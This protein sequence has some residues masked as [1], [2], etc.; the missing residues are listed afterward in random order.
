MNRLIVLG[1]SVRAAAFSAQRAGFAP[2][3]IDLFADCDLADACPAV[4]ISRYPAEFLTAL[5]AAPEAPWLYCGGLE[6]SPRLVDQLAMI[7]PLLGNRGGVLRLVRDPLRLGKAVREAGLSFPATSRATAAGGEW[8]IKPRRSS[9]GLGIRFCTKN[10]VSSLPRGAYL[11][12]YVDGDA[13]S[14]VFV[15]AGGRAVFLGATKQWLGRDFKMSRPFLYVGSIG[16]LRL[17]DVE[18]ERLCRLGNVLAERFGLTGLFNVDFVR[19]GEGLWPVEVNPRYSASMEVIE[20]M[21]GMALIDL[22]VAA[23]TSGLLPTQPI[24]PSQCCAGKAVVY[25]ERDAVVPQAL[26]EVASPWNSERQWPGL[27]DLPHVGEALRADQPVVTVFAEGKDAAGV[28]SEIRR[29]VATIHQLL[30]D[31]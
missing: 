17:S 9:G 21:K 13:A 31:L 1:A 28:E 2:Y 10:E 25:A 30:T 22:H 5:A 11:Q 4:K 24:P 12:Q 15:A 16:S 23:C 14:A 3:A 19:N 7:R 26:D 8:L 18:T 6:N 29:R 27:A 20:R